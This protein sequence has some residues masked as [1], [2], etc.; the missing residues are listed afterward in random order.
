[1]TFGVMQNKITQ[2]VQYAF[3]PAM[4]STWPHALPFPWLDYDS[5]A[6]SA[7]RE[8]VVHKAIGSFRT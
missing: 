8:Q 7:F 6:G 3:S 4:L 2:A 1:M 5:D